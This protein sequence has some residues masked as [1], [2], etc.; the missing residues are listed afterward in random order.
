MPLTLVQSQTKRDE[1]SWDWEVHLEGNKQDLDQIEY[2]EYALHETYPKPIRRIS[3]RDSGFQLK[4][5][6]WGEAPLYVTIHYKDEKR[7]SDYQ[8]YRLNFK[9]PT[10]QS[11]RW[12][13]LR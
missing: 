5:N 1:Y 6:G 2:V 4:E 13:A 12:M 7:R 11:A 10:T 3:D 8:A 9:E